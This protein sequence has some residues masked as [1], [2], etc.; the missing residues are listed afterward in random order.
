MAVVLLCDVEVLYGGVALYLNTRWW[1][2]C[3]WLPARLLLAMPLAGAP[4][5]RHRG[6][7]AAEQGSMQT[8]FSC[9]L[10]LQLLLPRLQYCL[11]H[12]GTLA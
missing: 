9:V 4:A 7:S 1:L 3:R 10:P 8:E 2:L 6:C 11:L 12:A 5:L